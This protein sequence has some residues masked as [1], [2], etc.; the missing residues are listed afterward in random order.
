MVGLATIRDGITAILA[1]MGCSNLY[2][3]YIEN[4]HREEYELQQQK[5][6]FIIA[7]AAEA[8]LPQFRRVGP[9]SRK[10]ADSA[11]CLSSKPP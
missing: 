8:V 5:V 6:N 11:K 1:S 2:F 3:F 7:C 4:T 10:G 9:S